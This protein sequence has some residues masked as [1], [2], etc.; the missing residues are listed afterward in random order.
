MSM[1]REREPSYK[2]K[3]YLLLF[4]DRKWWYPDHVGCYWFFSL[5]AGKPTIQIKSLKKL[6]VP[7][8][9]D[10]VLARVI[11]VNLR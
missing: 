1:R 8:V 9:G 11:M 10:I 6:V 2:M 5:L 3:L 4:W 7:D